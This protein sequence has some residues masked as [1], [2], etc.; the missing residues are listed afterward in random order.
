MVP[1]V[2]K[3]KPYNESISLYIIY[4]SLY[5]IYTATLFQPD[6]AQRVVLREKLLA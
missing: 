1:A 2:K 4:V 3:E 5:L 6:L